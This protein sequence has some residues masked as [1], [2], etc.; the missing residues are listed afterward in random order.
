MGLERNV[1]VFRRRRCGRLLRGRRWWCLSDLRGRSFGLILDRDRAAIFREE[2]LDAL[3]G[4][5]EN[6]LALLHEGDALGEAIE[7]VFE[8]ELAAFEGLDDLL[9]TRD[10]V[11]VLPA[12][13][14][15]FLRHAGCVSQLDCAPSPFG[16]L[17]RE[18]G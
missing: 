16:N 5:V 8:R 11:A 3:L 9:K 10:H 18:E 1:V 6:S 2:L 7:R 4:I 12:R 14:V 17:S 13:C 15:L